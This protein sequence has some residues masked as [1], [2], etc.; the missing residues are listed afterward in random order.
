MDLNKHTL[1]VKGDFEQTSKT[2]EI[3]INGGQFNIQGDFIQSGG[4][5]NI[6][7]GTLH[8][9]GDYRMETLT[10]DEEKEETTE[11]YSSG[12]LVM[13][14]EDDQVKVDGDFVVYSDAYSRLQA[15]TMTLL[16]NFTQKSSDSDGSSDFSASGTHTVIFAGTDKQTIYFENPQYSGFAY[17]SFQNENVKILSKLR[18]WTL[19][20][21]M[22]FVADFPGIVGSMDL[23]GHTLTVNRDFE[24]TSD[25]NS[26]NVN[27]GQLE[28]Q[29]DLLQSGGT[30]NIGG[31]TL[32]VT[33]DYR[34][35]TITTDEEGEKSES[36]S[37]GVLRMTNKADKV[38]VDGA[39]VMYSEYNHYGDLTAGTLTVCGAFRQI[40]GDSG[41]CYNF[42]A[43]DEH[44]TVLA[45]G[46]AESPQEVSFESEY[47]S[48]FAILKLLKTEENYSFT[49]DNCW[50]TLQQAGD[51]TDSSDE[52]GESSESGE[53]G[54]GSQ[55]GETTATAEPGETGDGSQTGGTGDSSAS[56][57][58][59]D[60]SAS[61]EIGDG[62]QSGGTTATAEPGETG[63]SSQSGGTT[64]T[65]KPGETGDSSQ[66]G[67]TTATAK[68]G[69]AGDSSQSGGTTA[70]AEP[71]EAGDG[72]QSGGT[73]ATAAP[74][75]TG[76]GSQ[77]GG[78]TAT[79]EPGETGDGSQSGGTTATAEPGEA[80]DGSQSGGTT[81]TAEPGETGDGS[82]SGG[83][84]VTAQP[85][86]AGT[87]AAPGTS[88]ASGSTEK[89]SST[90]TS[91]NT[92]VSDNTPSSPVAPASTTQPDTKKT[93]EKKA[94]VGT[95][96]KD[97]SGVT[98]KV[99]ATGEVEYTKPANQDITKVTIPSTVKIDGVEYKVTSISDNAFSG[100]SKLKSVTIGKNITSIGKR[101]F[102]NCKNLT[103]VTISAN[104]TKIGKQA[105]A[106]CSKLKTLIIK[107]TKLTEKS[108]GSNAFKGI[109][110]KAKVTVPKKQK[111]EYKKMLKKKGIPSTVKYKG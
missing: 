1:T 67:G 35:E 6:G 26:I 86:G 84:T 111:K 27:G 102:Y 25:T 3:N 41:S 17:A 15:G 57:E 49:P 69:E 95:E 52:S 92:A 7:G 36:S 63:D 30:M 79:A 62:S 47:S 105:F 54:D 82:Q 59:G 9:T 107:T 101:A 55:T 87:T 21:D 45:G 4:T 20:D 99:T 23:N 74:G 51:D 94:A 33:G 56:G 66:S 88:N 11:S 14:D 73:I 28:I 65:A 58:T 29:G 91:A 32:H 103:K 80:G 109:F 22:T 104:V 75:E 38:N 110:A 81:A 40:E 46:T 85:G 108:V 42:C 97:T 106:K 83:S 48:R 64:A 8:V 60:S 24:L 96:V 53:I 16:G 44:T 70:T 12:S 2:Y 72:S 19:S 68:P 90:S 43:S 5:M 61:G 10:T 78:T 77:S 34:I 37:C 98:Y 100:C 71:G 93:T 13:T 39:F 18:G 89:P 31:G 76:D 50:V